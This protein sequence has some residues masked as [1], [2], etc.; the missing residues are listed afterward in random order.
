L[1]IE[2]V[3]L[4]GARVAHLV[5]DLGRL[6][7]LLRLG[8]HGLCQRADEALGQRARVFERLGPIF[9]GGGPRAA[10][11]VVVG[12]LAHL[13]DRRRHVAQQ[14]IRLDDLA[15]VVGRFGSVRIQLDEQ[16]VGFD[17][18]FVASGRTRCRPA[19]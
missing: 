5:D 14:L 12:E 1:P 17:R 15:V 6:L 4:G 9:V 3:G 10:P 19:A 13:G 7:V 16:L 8:V 11:A 2:L 18:A